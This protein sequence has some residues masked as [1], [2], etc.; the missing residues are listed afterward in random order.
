VTSSDLKGTEETEA[1]ILNQDTKIEPSPMLPIFCKATSKQT[2]VRR[3][4]AGTDIEIAFGHDE[5]GVLL[6]PQ[7]EC[8]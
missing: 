1:Y 4:I 7:R 8:K 5:E 6:P 2:P 3:E